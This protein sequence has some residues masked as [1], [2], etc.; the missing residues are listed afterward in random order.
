MTTSKKLWL[1]F[2]VLIALL[3]LISTAIGVRIRFVEQ[4]VRSQADV[5]RPRSAATREIELGILRY[6]IAL[7]TYAVTRDASQ[8]DKG[9]EHIADVER[10]LAAYL[11]LA[12]TDQQR[13]LGERFAKL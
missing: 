13:K 7:R 9:L 8:R 2:G 10:H 12:S 4:A 1:G 6:A 5:S 11:R 3:M